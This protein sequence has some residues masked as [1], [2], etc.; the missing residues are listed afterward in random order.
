[1]SV[2]PHP[3]ASSPFRRILIKLSGEALMST[4]SEM[5]APFEWCGAVPPPNWYSTLWFQ[6]LCEA[7][8]CQPAA[9]FDSTARS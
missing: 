9:G 3:A 2:V 5:G 1:M 7:H 4:R 6:P 8:G